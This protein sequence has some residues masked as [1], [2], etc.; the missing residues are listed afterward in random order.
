MREPH[1]QLVHEYWNLPAAELLGVLASSVDGLAPAEAERRLRRYGMNT[2]QVARRLSLL[3]AVFRQV[4][5]PLVLIVLLA[6]AVSALLREWNDVAVLLVIIFIGVVISALQ[7]YRAGRAAAE[8]HDRLARSVTVVRAGQQQRIS[9]ARLVPGDVILLPAG[10]VVAADGVLLAADRCTA[11]EAMLTGESLPV[12]KQVGVTPVNAT[13]AQR[14]NCL[15]AGT[16][17]LS[18][19]AQLLVT[20]TG[21]TTQLG[22]IA[23]SLAERRPESAFERGIRR[24]GTVLTQVMLVLVLVVFTV[25]VIQQKPVA[26]ALLFAVA[27]AVGISPELLPA[28]IGIN[29]ADA[30]QRMAQ[31]GVLVRRLT[32]IE[33]LGAIDVLCTDKTGTLTE[34]RV[35]LTSADNLDGRPDQQILQ[36]AVTNA[37]ARSQ[38]ENPLDRAILAAAPDTA[39]T[40]LAEVP[41]DFVRRRISVV[42]EHSGGP[43]LIC[44]GAL[45]PLLPV[46]SSL[47]RADGDHA[48]DSHARA[49]LLEQLAQAGTGGTRLVGLAVRRLTEPWQ[50][51]PQ[52]ERELTLVGVLGFAD[53]LKS[54]SAAVVAALQARSVTVKIISGDNRFVTA[55]IAGAA[56][57]ST[58]AAVT[59][60]ELASLSTGAF[61][62]LVDRTSVFA[63]IDPRQKEQIILALRRRGRVVGFLGDGVND[64]PALHAA[65]VGIS[66]EG[67][68]DAAREAADIVLTRSDL[69]QLETGIVL[70]RK[71]FANTMKYLYITTSA[72]FGNMVSMAFSSAVLP[73]LPLLAKQILLNNILSDVPSLALSNDRVDEEA[74]VRPTQWAI[75]SLVQFMLLFG[76]ISSVFD[77]LTFALMIEYFHLAAGPFRTVWFIE[78]LLTELAVVFVFRT[79]RPLWRSRPSRLLVVGSVLTAVIAVLLPF[80]PWAAAL[81]FAAV[82]AAP[83]LTAFGLTIGYTLVTEAAKQRFFRTGRPSS[84]QPNSAQ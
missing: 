57:I 52:L 79:H 13:P 78:S 35:R 20:A 51:G 40:V 73:F 7:E 1:P 55:Q 9:A 43:L 23:A 44:K 26:E 22:T 74:T 71:T 49:Q 5:S 62:H 50:A 66:V 65:D 54:D 4:L 15:L 31:A 83:I 45:E 64:T 18:G 17:L 12:E 46:C 63:E 42:T 28:V 29:L 36:W 25:N 34:G 16:N 24:F 27:L 3:Q 53:A 56:G 33:N 58:S 6:V 47:R 14:F 61:D 8:L 2:V 30:S 75:G 77:L 60:S 84:L 69:G 39:L 59:G 41:F 10:A 72:N 67:A 38:T 11:N 21:R 37:S 76:L 19:S 80:S 48:L 82:G 70:G 32:A 68:A 81:G